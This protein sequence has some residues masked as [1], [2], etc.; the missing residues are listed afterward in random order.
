MCPRR[1]Q[2][3]AAQVPGL[4]AGH[5]EREEIAVED[6]G[7]VHFLTTVSEPDP[8]SRQRRRLPRP[9]N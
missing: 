5:L 4:E 2:D 6:R 1:M 9:S 7:Q 3:A 8:D